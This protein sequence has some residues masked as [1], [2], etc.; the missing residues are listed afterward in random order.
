MVLVSGPPQNYG[1]APPG[2][3]GGIPNGPPFGNAP[4]RSPFPPQG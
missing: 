4:M 1:Q 3:K 2:N